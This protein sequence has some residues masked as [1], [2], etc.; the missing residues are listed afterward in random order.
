MK[1][2][3][4]LLF[5]VAFF[6]LFG[7]TIQAQNQID[8]YVLYNSIGENTTF[9]IDKNR[10]IAHTWNLQNPCNYT[11]LLKDNGNIVRGA[12]RTNNAI[13]GPA[14]GGLLQEI[15]PQGNIVWE[16]EYSNSDHVLHHDITLMPNDNV[17]LTAWEVKRASELTERGY[18]G[19]IS[20]RYATHFIEVSQAGTGGEI[21]WEW[22]IWDHMIQDT[23]PGK[24]NYGVV[25]NHPELMNIN[26]AVQGFGGADWFHVNGVDYNEE[27]DQIAF[28]SRFLS[29]IFI[30]DHSTTTEE[31]AG[32][33]GGNAG[34]GGDFLYRWGKPSNYRVQGTQ[35]IN[36]PVHDVRWIPNDGRPRGGFLQ[37]FNNIGNGS[38]S[39]VDAIE[40]PFSA[41][42][43]NYELNS[44]Q[45]Y[46]PS[47][48]DWRHTCF[49]NAQGQSSSITLPNGNTFVNLSS[50]YMYEVNAL[51]SLIWQYSAGP[52][53]AFRYTCNHPGIQALSNQGVIENLCMVSSVDDITTEQIKISPN[54][55]NGLFQ[56]H[57]LPSTYKVDNI[58]VIDLL[59]KTIQ[60]FGQVSKLDLSHQKAGIY[61]IKIQFDNKKVVTQKVSIVK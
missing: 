60:T 8:G 25:K 46:L 30:I 35:T 23:D 52:A 20:Q 36:G 38:A 31:A 27:L 2:L 39:T 58:Q 51:G 13:N 10:N 57:H 53:K 6:L 11:V 22:H 16:F 37:Y 56:I 41:D 32:H 28:S 49:G 61:F 21:V 24:V 19:N 17:L 18:V 50:Q 40:L 55:S 4:N 48:F 7:S 9:L 3:T 5:P 12:I 45:A 44:G 33:T 43:Y 34:K 14:V 42:G 15:D 29:E 26:V 54:P 1:I 47:T 59:G